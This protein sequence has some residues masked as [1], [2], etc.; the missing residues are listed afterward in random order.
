[1]R[2]AAF[3]LLAGLSLAC[4]CASGRS[5]SPPS[6]AKAEPREAPPRTPSETK[7]AL[8]KAKKKTPYIAMPSDAEA[9]KAMP[10]LYPQRPMPHLALVGALQPKSM[11]AV[12]TTGVTVRREG[13][14]DPRL[15]NDVFWVVS[16]VNECFY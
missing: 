16:N 3:S 15:I 10:K 9:H 8:E 14:L 7:A 6:V 11:E 13:G 12:L 5:A 4:G 1:M 2:G